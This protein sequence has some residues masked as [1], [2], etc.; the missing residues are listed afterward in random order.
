MDRSFPHRR[1]ASWYEPETNL[2]PR[3]Y[4]DAQ[5]IK[6]LDQVP[7]GL[8]ILDGRMVVQYLNVHSENYLGVRRIE[9]LGRNIHAVVPRVGLSYIDELHS[10]VLQSRGRASLMCRS[11]RLTGRFM[12]ITASFTD[13]DVVILLRDIPVQDSRYQSLVRAY[14]NLLA[15]SRRDHL[16]GILNRSALYDEISVLS[17][18]SGSPTSL[19][20]IDIDDFKA[21]NDKHGHV[22]G[23]LVL[24]TIARRLVD[25]CDDSVV[26]GRVG[27]DEFV[28]AIFQGKHPTS[29]TQVGVLVERMRLSARRPIRFG[30]TH[31][32]VDLSVGIAYNEHDNICLTD[33]LSEADLSLY[34]DKATRGRDETRSQVRPTLPSEVVIVTD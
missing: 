2:N 19:L 13:G 10:H 26:V 31:V 34:R 30:D 20:F 7:A 6:A 11:L 3:T 27:G 9:L 5:A 17:R 16:T 15:K 8:I 4:S 1:L 18:D 28:A 21:I 33:L 25:Q 32:S 23:D 14:G 12:L 29:A 22:C 24:R